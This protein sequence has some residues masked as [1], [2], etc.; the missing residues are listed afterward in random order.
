M[1]QS[2]AL[3]NKR[4]TAV[5]K[6]MGFQPLISDPSVYTKGP[7][8]PDQQLVACWVDDILFLNR[9]D[10][11]QGRADFNAQLKSHFVMSEWTEGEADFILNIRID[12]D[13]KA[14][15]IKI[16]QPAA[17]EKLARKFGL[18]D[19]KATGAPVIPMKPDL[20]L[21]KAVGDEIVPREE[22]DYPSIVG[23]L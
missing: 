6:S 14:G 16:S 15:T 13:W 21:A 12:R 2:S 23:S 1:K 18:D 20:R 3:L 19:I 5:L 8:G 22:F 10:D 4:L 9:R 11:K 7:P 17:V